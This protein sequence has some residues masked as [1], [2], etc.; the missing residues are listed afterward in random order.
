MFAR[1]K[2]TVILATFLYFACIGTALADYH[3]QLGRFLQRDPVAT[4]LPIVENEH[5]FHGRPP[6]IYPSIFD[7]RWH[8]K[9]GLNLCE[10]VGSNPV[11][12]TDPLGL[13]WG[14]ED[15]IDAAMFEYAY[16]LMGVSRQLGEARA[17]LA[18]GAQLAAMYAAAAFLWDELVWDQ[19]EAALLG[20]V[21]GGFFA[22]ACFEEGTLVTLED[23]T[24]VPIEGLNAGARV[25]SW[26]AETGAAG[27]DGIVDPAKWRLI[28]LE[29]N[30]AERGTITISLL[31]DL[32]WVSAT[33]A[34]PGQRLRLAVAEMGIHGWAEVCSVEPCPPEAAGPAAGLVT[35]TFQTE[36]ATL[37]SVF[38]DSLTEPIGAT[39]LH[40]FYSLDRN[41]WVGAGNL[42]GGERVR[43]SNG[44]AIINHVETRA[45]VQTV[46]NLEVQGTHTYFVSKAKVWVHNAC[47]PEQI[48]KARGFRSGMGDPADWK[49]M[50][51]KPGSGAKSHDGLYRKM[52]EIWKDAYGEVRE[53]HYFLRPDGSI[54]DLKIVG[55]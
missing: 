7:A 50:R 37:V 4:G 17:N 8:Y 15:D 36:K 28:R 23:G 24:I 44:E 55:G 35:G 51:M 12:R 30:D 39:A 19:G 49:F 31:R 33:R 42:R 26:P 14:M 54:F 21:T 20:L 46:Y 32:T 27:A 22:R 48:G 38:I 5:W 9:S 53:L 25:M 6:Q 16:G 43:T 10:Y 3:P 45:T 13:D 29:A 52:Y 2:L 11:N 18:Q 1:S 34:E 41:A 40:P 47:T